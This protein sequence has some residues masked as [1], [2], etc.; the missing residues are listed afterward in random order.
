MVRH[1]RRHCTLWKADRSPACR[2]VMMTLDAM[3]IDVREVDVNM[4]KE[5]H[6]SPGIIS[7][8]PLQTL[9]ILKDRDLV[10]SDSHAISTY[11]ATRYYTEMSKFLLPADPGSRAIVDQFLYFNSSVLHPHY[12]AASNPILE[13]SLRIVDE[14]IIDGIHSAYADLERILTSR[15]WFSN[16]SWPSLGDIAIAASISTLNV[17]VPIDVN[18]FPRLSSWLHRMSEEK[19][20]CTANKK[21]LCEFTRRIE[22]G[23][24]YNPNEAK[25]PRNSEERRNDLSNTEPDRTTTNA[26]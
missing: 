10:I 11:L 21:G 15:S 19:F 20:F 1:K 23:N 7:M 12:R 14:K 3:N 26:A 18:K 25:Y 22:Y 8:N 17:L 6:K 4:D 9:P 5:E 24:C 13:G 16:G 2:S